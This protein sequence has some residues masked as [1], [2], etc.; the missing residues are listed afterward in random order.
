MDI[1]KET[2]MA[3]RKEESI[4][5]D[6]EIS[7]KL[8]QLEQE[9][10][11]LQTVLKECEVLEYKEKVVKNC[12]DVQVRTVIKDASNEMISEVIL[13][14]RDLQKQITCEELLRILRKKRNSKAVEKKEMESKV[15][16]L[17]EKKI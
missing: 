3:P 9:I 2:N 16:E 10:Q 15:K 5:E 14:E 6:A 4:Q 17:V 1:N 7:N 13:A 8:M 11:V 12:E